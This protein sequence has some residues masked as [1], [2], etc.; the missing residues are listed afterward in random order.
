M[1]NQYLVTVTDIEN[2]QSSDLPIFILIFL[3]CLSMF[4]SANSRETLK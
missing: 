4:I 1:K 3:C 2:E